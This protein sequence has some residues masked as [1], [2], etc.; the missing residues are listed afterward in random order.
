MAARI[1]AASP[2]GMTI[3][4]PP[5]AAMRATSAASRTVPA[6]ISARSPNASARRRM[7]AS[8]S[9]ELSGTSIATKPASTSALADRGRLG[10]RHAA[11]DRDQRQGR[12]ELLQQR[13]S[14]QAR[15]ARDQE[16][17]AGAG[18][19]ARRPHA[20]IARG[21]SAPIAPGELGAADHADLGIRRPPGSRAPPRSRCRSGGR[22]GRRR[23]RTSGSTSN[24]PSVRALNSRRK[25]PP[26]P[27]RA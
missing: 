7:L 12:Q 27:V 16:L 26:L 9:G 21:E 13:S 17:A 18:I 10:R 3:S 19:V 4:R 23:S 5:A 14:D 20:Q 6:P 25:S 15:R 1:T 11:Q 8:G 22:T 24:R 2:C